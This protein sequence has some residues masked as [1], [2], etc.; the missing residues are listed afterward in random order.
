MPL[1]Q[2]KKNGTVI[3]Y[4]YDVN[5]SRVQK[6][7]SGGTNTYYIN[8]P[9]GKTEAVQTGTANSVYTYN[10]WGND[11]LGQVKDNAGSLSRFY[12]LKDHL[13]DIK[14]VLN[15]SG[16]VDSY[17]DYYP[18]GMQM[19]GRNLTGT[20]DGR[21]K[22]IGVEQDVETGLDATGFRTYNSWSGG[23]GQV[24]PL[25][26]LF[27][28]QGSYGY[29][30]DN[31]SRY[32]DPGGLDGG[33]N[34]QYWSVAWQYGP[35]NTINYFVTTL[36][37]GTRSDRQDGPDDLL[38]SE[39]AGEETCGW[40]ESMDDKTGYYCQYQE[41]QDEVNDISDWWSNVQKGIKAYQQTRMTQANGWNTASNVRRA[42][43][44]ANAVVRD[45]TMAS[46]TVAG[47]TKVTG[48]ALS[49]AA[50]A[51][52]LARI[53]FDK[54]YK[55]PEFGLDESSTLTAIETGLK[56]GASSG[57]LTG[58]GLWYAKMFG[59]YYSDLFAGENLNSG[60]SAAS[61]RGQ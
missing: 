19:P 61:G 28:D 34:N 33:D 45:L 29:S 52:P 32:S 5:G 7:A 49:G 47:I 6:Y 30:F 35:D 38:P 50:I 46:P 11:M 54:N 41:I 27:A 42:A 21:F 44:T 31:P 3:Q 48:W 8:D 2:Y 57:A 25:S 58:V 55:L 23:F 53:I 37:N 15:Q 24:D 16:G 43:G 20:A 36:T 51:L 18:F 10:I 60:G 9:T 17:N 1:S 4:A 39:Y 13:G 26:D 56:L 22:F 59:S 14:M 40:T 12:Y